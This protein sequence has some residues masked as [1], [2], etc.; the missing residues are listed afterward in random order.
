MAEDSPL[1]EL[2]AEQVTLDIAPAQLG[3]SSTAELDPIDEIVGQPRALKALD[4]GLGI[5]HPNY[6]VYAA[7]TSGTGRMEMIRRVVLERITSD[8]PP[9]DWLY[10]NNFDEPDRPLAISLPAGQGI[11]L[12]CDMEQLVATLEES[13]PK[14]F[15]RED[16]GH[17]KQRL[18]K[19]YRQRGEEAFS[20]LQQMAAEKG[21]AV[22]QLPEGQIVFL[23]LKDDRPMTPQ[24]IQELSQENIQA[25]ES[26]QQE[27]VEKAGTVIARQQ[28]IE[29]QLTADVRKVAREFASRLIDPLVDE[30]AGRYDSEK[31]SQWLE[32]FKAH[33][34]EN[35]D[36]FREP[37]QIPPAF[38]L[39]MGEIGPA[40]RSERF[41]E[42]RVNLL[43]DNSNVDKSPVVIE[44]A[45]HHRNLFGTVER[46]VDRMGRAYSNFTRIKAGSLLKANGGYLIL[47]LMDAL[48][49]PFVWK[50]LKRTLKNGSLEFQVYDPFSLFAT[51]ALKPEPI[52]LKTRLIALGEPLIY[53]LLY[54]YDEDFREIFRV[55]SDF[56]NE[57][58]RDEAAALVYGRFVRKLSDS[59]DLLPFDA[60]GVAEL[61]QAG[62]RLVHDRQ[63]LSTEF[64]RIADVVRESDYWARQE[65]GR[66]VGRRH[67]R[68]AL[69]QRVYRSD[70][71]AAKIRELIREGTL[72]FS[73]EGRAAGQV[74]GLAVAD[75]GDYAFGRPTRVTASIGVGSVG[76][77]NIERE[78]RLSG[79][80]FDKGLFILE[81]YLRNT[82][83]Q[84]CALALAASVAMEQSYGGIDGDSASVAEL[85]A[86]LSAI[87]DIPL[88]QDLAVT[89]SVNQKGEVQAVGGVNEKIEGLFDVARAVE[90]AGE[91]GVCI[92]AANSKNLV[93]REDVA[94]AVREGRFHLW[95]V[96]HIDQVIALFAGMPAGNVEQKGTFHAR[97]Q[98]RLHELADALKGHGGPSGGKSIWTPGAAPPP[99]RDPRPPL[100]GDQ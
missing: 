56:D 62:A 78:S 23:P 95:P 66:Q 87:A 25:L 24:E 2:T 32:K 68:R 81:G 58:D 12:K 7:G 16:F 45:P 59:E 41:L 43:V 42:Y 60:E 71:I 53:H 29:R 69:Q 28:E 34:L 75:L 89:G 63:K 11:G 70:L 40:D 31:L 92:P 72:L 35:L 76:V 19:Q 8:S 86:L 84:Q 85:L 47:N 18:R 82:Y 33:V 57:M 10:V 51:S 36:R 90:A 39:A 5:R 21:M 20:E 9:P 97:V 1:R 52:P 30:I 91:L 77:I 61:V 4:L 44:D 88:R 54:L 80:T 98:A 38:A 17:E 65:D 22:Q 74:N 93:L 55:K 26:A 79:Q 37:P 46:V 50:E 15:R 3:F 96:E 6:H 99:P 67:V 100:P 94:A 64:S 49:E 14:A 83:A 27:L 13:L 48:T 73:F